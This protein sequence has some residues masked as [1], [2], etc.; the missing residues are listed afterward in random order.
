M[1]GG[2]L[3]QGTN[4]PVSMGIKEMMGLKKSAKLA[5]QDFSAF[6]GDRHKKIRVS[7]FAFVYDC[8]LLHP[9]VLS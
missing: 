4:G 9:S 2:T 5:R 7:F 8:Y 3:A 6:C 1:N